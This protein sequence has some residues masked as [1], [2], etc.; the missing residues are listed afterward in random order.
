LSDFLRSVNG[1]ADMETRFTVRSFDS[2]LSLEEYRK[3]PRN[4]VYVVLDNLRS[5]YNV[6]SV[7]RTADAGCI[8]KVMPCGYTA[9]PPH[10][11]LVKTA[12]GTDRFVASEYFKSTADA[13][14]SV[15]TAGMP[16]VA[17][18][19]VENSMK[20]TDFMF[21]RPVC[22][23]VGNEALGVSPEALALADHVVS[24]PLHGFKNSLNVVCAFAVVLFEI[25]RQWQKDTGK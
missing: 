24:I 18:E 9:C 1:C 8:E 25:L 4:P 5:A 23:V 13:I 2:P 21:P 7:F 10:K 14:K 3:L 17:L 6:G 22:L 15:R 11:K 12:L 16:V 20:Y 19:T